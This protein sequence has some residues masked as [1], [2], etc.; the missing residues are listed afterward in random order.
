M[1]VEV[2]RRHMEGGN[3]HQHIAKV[4]WFNHDNSKIDVST[5]QQMVIFLE[6]GGNAYVAGA[7]SAS[8]PIGVV[9]MADGSKH[10]RTYAD[11]KWT[12]NL[13]SLPEF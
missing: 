3:D 5:V 9:K 13:L 11:G 7:N 2:F 6:G 4:E 8:I 12:N 10:I 1:L